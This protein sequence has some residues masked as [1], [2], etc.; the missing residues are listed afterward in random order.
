MRKDWDT[1]EEDAAWANLS[2]LW[3]VLPVSAS[4]D[5]N[6]LGRVVKPPQIKAVTGHRTPKSRSR[7]RLMLVYYVWSN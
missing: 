2:A 1:P 6:S 4:A 7:L 5:L 3:S